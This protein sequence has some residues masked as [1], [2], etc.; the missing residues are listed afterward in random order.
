MGTRWFLLLS[1]V[2]K[3]FVREIAKYYKCSVDECKPIYDALLEVKNA[4]KDK[5]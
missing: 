2:E 4:I 3:E 5:N 1:E